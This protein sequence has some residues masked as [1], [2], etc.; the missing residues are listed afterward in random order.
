MRIKLSEKFH[1]EREDKNQKKDDKD[2][3]VIVQI[4]ALFTFFLK[5]F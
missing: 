3:K 1:S 2:K 4:D 5:I